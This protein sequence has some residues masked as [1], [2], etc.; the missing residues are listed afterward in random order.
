MCENRLIT[1][2]LLR[3]LR[4][5]DLAAAHQE[6]AESLLSSLPDY[7]TYEKVLRAM[8]QGHM[9]FELPVVWVEGL[10][11]ERLDQLVRP[12][13]QA[14]LDTL[15]D[16]AHYSWRLHRE[17]QSIRLRLAERERWW[18]TALLAVCPRHT[19]TCCCSLA[20]PLLKELVDAGL[21]TPDSLR[22]TEAFPVNCDASWEKG[23]FI[24]WTG[25]SCHV[26]SNG[27]FYLY[28]G[29]RLVGTPLTGA[30]SG[31]AKTIRSTVTRLA[32][33]S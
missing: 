23:F 9:E 19:D 14:H 28:Q 32:A 16:P 11:L 3:D 12:A 1:P 4:E 26:M 10:Q 7:I 17:G 22:I 21:I 8:Q 15:V 18:D 5:A 25:F 29:A 13:M 2:Q 20:T 31:V 33:T 6:F 30:P 24:E 27:R